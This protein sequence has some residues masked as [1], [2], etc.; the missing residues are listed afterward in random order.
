MLFIGIHLASLTTSRFL[1]TARGVKSR[2]LCILLVAISTA[3]SS[4]SVSASAALEFSTIQGAGGVPLTV[5]QSGNRSGPQI[6]FIHGFSQSYLSW[7]K[8]LNDRALQSNFHLVALDLRGHGS[9]GKPSEASSYT[10]EAW[11]GDIAA[12][13]AAT[14][15]RHPVLVGWSMGGPV[16]MSYLKHNGASHIAGV[17]FV[18]AAQMFSAGD[19]IAPVDVWQKSHIKMMSEMLSDDLMVNYAGTRAFVGELTAQPLPSTEAESLFVY[20]MM[21]PP[22]VRRSVLAN[23]PDWSQFDEI[24]PSMTI[25]ILITHGRADRLVAY[26]QSLNM[27]RYFPAATFSIYERTGHAPFLER[28][29][30]FNRELARFTLAANGGG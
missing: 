25:P 5:V 4:A 16:A 28:P 17:A 14:G 26:R 18:D 7:V 10:S 13:I 2:W 12:V 1:A 30:R 29:I 8:Q 22:Y 21:T 6:I 27:K 19:G 20:N 23:F 9:S 3:A 24:V 11:A 15:N